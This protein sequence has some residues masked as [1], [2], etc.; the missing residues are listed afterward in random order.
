MTFNKARRFAL[1][2]MREHLAGLDQQDGGQRLYNWH[3]EVFG[4]EDLEIMA[5]RK[6]KQQAQGSELSAALNFVAVAGTKDDAPYKSHVALNNNFAVC[7]DGQISAGHPIVEELECCPQLS[8]LRAALAKTGESLSITEL[9]T[10]QLAIVGDRLTAKISCLSFD[11]LPDVKLT[12]PDPICAAIDDRIKQAFA[13]CGGVVSENGTRAFECGMLLAA[14]ECT[15]INGKVLIQYWHGIDLPPDLFVPKIFTAAVCKI[16]LPLV[17]FG[18]TLG[19]SVTFHFQGGAWIKTQ[20]YEDKF[21]AVASIINSAVELHPNGIT[22]ELFDA[23]A[24]IADFSDDGTATLGNGCVASTANENANAKYTLEGLPGNLTLVGEQAKMIAPYVTS[25]DLTSHNDRAFFF[26]DKMRGVI[27]GCK[28]HV[29]PRPPIQ[30][31]APSG[32]TVYETTEQ[33]R[34]RGGPDSEIPF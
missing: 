14:N 30:E 1:D 15:S 26:G 16:K 18:F 7:C 9:G 34:A 33:W 4:Q 19:R 5:A 22:P 17:G 29:E 13:V 21:P 23:I 10:G 2:H 6:A 32:S 11:A 20:L 3:I 24:T 31:N 27:M 8:Q 12:T 25:I 28:A